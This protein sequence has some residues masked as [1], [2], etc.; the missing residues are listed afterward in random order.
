[1]HNIK[2]NQNTVVKFRRKSG[3]TRLTVKATE[4]GFQLRGGGTR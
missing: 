3:E 1:M 4:R 2:K